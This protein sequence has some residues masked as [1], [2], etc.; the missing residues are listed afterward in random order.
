MVCTAPQIQHNAIHNNTAQRRKVGCLY[1]NKKTHRDSYREYYRTVHT[2][3]T[4]NIQK[5][6]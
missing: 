1:N 5:V 2:L 6:E 3:L 4:V